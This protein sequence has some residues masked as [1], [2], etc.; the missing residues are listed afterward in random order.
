MTQNPGIHGGFISTYRARDFGG[1]HVVK[2]DKLPEALN[3]SIHLFCFVSYE[4][5]HGDDDQVRQEAGNGAS[6]NA[7][8]LGGDLVAL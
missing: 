3:D 7:L 8:R 4:I 2:P 5:F 6:G 1:R